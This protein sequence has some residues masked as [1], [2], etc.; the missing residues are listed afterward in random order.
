QT[1]WNSRI[2]TIS[3]NENKLADAAQHQEMR[4]AYDGQ[5][6]VLS[7]FCNT[8]SDINVL[9]ISEIS[10]SGTRNTNTVNLQWQSYSVT[11]GS[12]Q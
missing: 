10:S 5:S 9:R 1:I 11:G 12:H 3:F 7:V 4:S 2:K 8:P 6:L